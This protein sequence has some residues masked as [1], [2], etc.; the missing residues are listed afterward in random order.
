MDH[1]ATTS[2][3]GRNAWHSL[4]L[5]DV[6]RQEEI[7]ARAEIDRK[8]PWFSGHF[9]GE[10]ILPGIAQLHMVLEAIQHAEGIDL[11][12]KGLKR[13]R[14]KKVIQ[15]EDEIIIITGPLEDNPFSYSFRI[16]VGGELACSGILIT[17]RSNV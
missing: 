17:E 14:F 16:L 3:P 10:P 7:V 11:K 2:Q 8:S 1:K 13:V 9:P 4:V 12:L 15:P 6:N 5:E